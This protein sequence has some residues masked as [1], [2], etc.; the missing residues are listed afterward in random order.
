VGSTASVRNDAPLADGV[1]RLRVRVA[2][3]AGRSA[4]VGRL[5]DTW[6][7]RVTAAAERGR[8]NAAVT[9][10]LADA[11]GLPPRRVRIVAG[12]TSR[13]KVVAVEG[14]AFEEAERRL[15]GEGTA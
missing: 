9:R 14:L 2:P 1:T 10:L 8:A 5:G 15:A 6:K 13:D 7:L 4:V 12:H 3:G 11:L